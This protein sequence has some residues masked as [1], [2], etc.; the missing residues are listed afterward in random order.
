MAK[1]KHT[2]HKRIEMG[3]LFSVRLLLVLILFYVKSQFFDYLILI[4]Y[5]KCIYVYRIKSL[6]FSHFHDYVL[7]ISF[8]KLVVE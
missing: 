8:A 6:F 2:L 7:Q 3:E 1:I 4:I 5:C